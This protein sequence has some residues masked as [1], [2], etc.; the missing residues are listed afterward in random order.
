MVAMVTTAMAQTIME[1]EVGESYTINL[2]AE[3]NVYGHVYYN[4]E[5]T[6]NL[7]YDATY[8]AA[9]ATNAN[10]HFVFTEAGTDANGNKL[11]Y[12][13]PKN[14]DGVYAYNKN[15]SNGGGSQNSV[16]LTSDETVKTEK[17]KWYVYDNGTYQFIVP[18]WKD[19]DNYVLGGCCW[20]AWSDP[21]ENYTLGMWGRGAGNPNYQG[22][23]CLKIEIQSR[24][25]KVN[26]ANGKYIFRVQNNRNVVRYNGE[27]LAKGEVA[28]D[29]ADE[30]HVFTITKGSNG[31]YSI[32]TVDGKYVTYSSTAN[33][34][35]IAVSDA[36][37]ATDANKW[38]SI[39]EGSSSSSFR[40]I[41]P[42]TNDVDG[43]PGW[44]YATT[45]N[46]V[47]NAAVG[48]WT[49]TGDGSQWYIVKAAEVYTGKVKMKIANIV[50]SSNGTNIVK[51]DDENSVFTI[52]RGENGYYTIQ[53]TDNS[54][55]TYE[56]KNGGDAVKITAEANATDDNKWWV[57]AYD[58]TDRAALDIFP[59]QGNIGKDTPSLNWSID[60][61]GAANTGLG[62]W[63]ASDANSY[64]TLDMVAAE[65]LYYIKATGTGNDA[66]WYMTFENGNDWKAKAPTAGKLNVNYIWSLEA[67]DNGY[68][69]KSCNLNK[70]AEL[71][72]A[73]E[74][75]GG[76]SH[77]Q[78]EY[79]NGSNFIFTNKG[80]NVFTIKD[81]NNNVVRSEG[82]GA[83]NYWWGET[84]ETWTLIPVNEIDITLS[85]IAGEGW[86][87][88]YLPFDVTLP[89]GLTAYYVSEIN[90]GSVILTEAND[91][92][93]NN[94]VVLTG[95]P[96]EYTLNIA[97]A[98]SEITG[99][100]L[101]GTTIDTEITKEEGNSYYVL[102][103]KNGIGF[104]NAVLGDDA[105]K[106]KNAANKA[107]LVVPGAS[108]VASYSFRFGEGTTGIDQI[109]DNRVQSTVIYDLTG[110]RVE[111]I[112]APGIYI[113]GGK[114]VLVK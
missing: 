13:S 31:F 16:G 106:F 36:A 39:R 40:T 9:N 87:T 84:N 35:T 102:A 52:N 91:V 43:A 34:A 37:D 14:A 97:E 76:P 112:S 71:G 15:E 5:S 59:K 46:N 90:N 32:Q 107:Y 61:T 1:L 78:S 69:M 75:S 7:Y 33:G 67:C 2:S 96:G 111:N 64:V 56:G 38:W 8:T 72:N 94:G 66:N 73:E 29:A 77:F 110:R 11:Y 100:Y 74:L 99:N 19:G 86:A 45:I 53:T 41:V 23:N 114:K 101:A 65:G 54:F 60:A 49:S 105:T 80:G 79:D 103:N 47:T 85:D 4:A 42:S 26:L 12:I 28:A 44:N 62:F 109:T 48:L 58:V 51:A 63:G 6:D 17:G 30:N 10:Y 83:L 20:N 95:T 93:A 55:L 68:K 108:E 88:A 22:D 98:T 24:E 50:A 21:A 27:I 57:I 81:G 89:E 104:Y 82:S 92:P 25:P 70:Y 18:A 113:V 3:S